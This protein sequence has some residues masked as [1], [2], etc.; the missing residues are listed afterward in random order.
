MTIRSLPPVEKRYK[1]VYESRADSLKRLGSGLRVTG[2]FDDPAGYSESQKIDL[3]KRQLTKG[4]EN[5]NSVSA[6]VEQA[7]EAINALTTI[8][9]KIDDLAALASDQLIGQTQRAALD[10]DAQRLRTQYLDIVSSTS[11]DG[12]ALLNGEMGAI[13]VEAGTKR[14]L[15]PEYNVNLP[16]LVQATKPDGTFASGTTVT[17][18]NLPNNFATGDLNGD[19]IID[20]VTSY[21]NDNK[22]GVLLGNGDGTFKAQVTYGAG[23]GTSAVS[24]SDLDGDGD[25]DLVTTSITDNRFNILKNNG[26]GTFAALV[27]YAG[28]NHPFVSHD[29][30]DLS[31]DGIVDLVF[32][33]L[34]DDVVQVYIGNGNGTFKS[35]VSYL[36]GVGTRQATVGD[37]NGDGFYDIVST[38]ETDNT[39]SVFINNGNGTFKAEVSYS[40]GSESDT[41]VTADFNND[42]KLD[43]ISG[44]YGEGTVN[45]FTGNGDGTFKSRVSYGAGAATRDI[46]FGDFNADG[47]LDIVTAGYTGNAIHVLLGNGD[48][49]LRAQVPYYYATQARAVKTG[50]FNR[51]GMTDIMLADDLGDAVKMFLGQGAST[52][53]SFSLLTSESATAAR[54]LVSA[55][56]EELYS[57]QGSVSA[58]ATRL[59]YSAYHNGRLVNTFD[60]AHS[61]ITDAEKASDLANL[62]RTEIL[63]ERGKALLAQAE[64]LDLSV[65]VNLLKD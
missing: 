55:K 50:D 63:L 19:G 3:T 21:Y 10:A 38:A 26:N 61:R 60:V 11:Y 29:L 20:L 30:K 39:V 37:V 31:G 35:S 53:N 51:D 59:E 33:D 13:S 23:D 32:G 12:K 41:V 27:S 9:S 4:I 25:L 18:G 57:Q 24:V 44:S 40:A 17:T 62:T 28:G 2:P 7:S 36:A 8:L 52:L 22:A 42:G 46:D 45:V 58:Q 54:Y 56:Y 5:L 64:K 49:T 15:S 48:G 47:N 65:V 16:D 1:E 43:I 6:V 34:S 14:S